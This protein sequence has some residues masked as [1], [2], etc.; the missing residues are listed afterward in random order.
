ME[1]RYSCSLST[2][3]LSESESLQYTYR[4]LAMKMFLEKKKPI[5]KKLIKDLQEFKRNRTNILDA[6]G[7]RRELHDKYDNG[8]DDFLELPENE[9]EKKEMR[10]FAEELY[11]EYR[12][13][14][15][16]LKGKPMEPGCSCEE[17]V[18]GRIRKAFPEFIKQKKDG[19]CFWRRRNQYRRS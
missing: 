9:E 18:Y 15:K 12:Q 4:R 11:E 13:E 6:E 16:Y 5:P 17:C 14:D 19:K 10:K 1:S 8:Y 7:I 3:L 2:E